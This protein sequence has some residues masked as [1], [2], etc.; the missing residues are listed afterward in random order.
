MPSSRIDVDGRSLG[1]QP[2]PPL[3]P[4]RREIAEPRQAERGKIRKAALTFGHDLRDCMATRRRKAEADARHGGDRRVVDAGQAIDDRSSVGRVFD[5]PGPGAN[6]A[7]MS[8]FGKELCEA[9]GDIASDWT[10][11]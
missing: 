9:F 3:A 11:R 8:R 5:D 2:A 1:R 4:A 6:D 10:R 7:R